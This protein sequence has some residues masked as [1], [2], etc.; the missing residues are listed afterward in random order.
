M[1]TKNI[2]DTHNHGEF[3]GDS[4]STIQKSV[5]AAIEKGLGGITF[6]DHYEFPDSLTRAKPHFVEQA[7]FD[8]DH[9]QSIIDEI[10][11]QHPNIKILKGIEIGYT[12]ERAHEAIDL[13]NKYSFDH[14]ILSIHE[15][16]G[17]DPWRGEFYDGKTYKEAYGQ[18]LEAL[19]KAMHTLKN[20]DSLGHYDYIAR[21]PD[22]PET[23]VLYKDFPDIL[24]EIF[25]YLIHEG[26]AIEINTKTY[27]ELRGRTPYIDI[28]VFKRYK[29]LGGELICLASDS[30]LASKVGDRLEWAASIVESAG[31]KHFTYFENRKPIV[32]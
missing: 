8:I 28:N 29:E 7:K 30:H 14:I 26:K 24:D 18:Y 13:L 2:F 23:A 22:Y 31:F 6:T 17:H 5:E 3:S 10:Q 19:Y 21:Y 32:V 9:Q 12:E 25:K 16:E 20:F 1:D 11:L 4:R 27:I 15:L